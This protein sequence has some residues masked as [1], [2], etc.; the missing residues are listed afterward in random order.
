MANEEVRKME[1]KYREGSHV[2]VRIL[3][4]RNLEGFAMGTLKV[5]ITSFKNM[6]S[7]FFTKDGLQWSGFFFVDFSHFHIYYL[8]FPCA[9]HFFLNTCIFTK[10]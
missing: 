5:I 2:R 6:S 4:F 9:L 10:I 8:S 3:G 7:D 1:K